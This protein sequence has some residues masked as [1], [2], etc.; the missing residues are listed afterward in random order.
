MKNGILT[1]LSILIL[2]IIIPFETVLSNN[3]NPLIFGFSF[4]IVNHKLFKH[5]FLTGLILTITFSYLAFFIGFFGLFGIGEIIKW[6]TD[7]FNLKSL[8]GDILI[9]FSGLI[10]SLILYLLFTKVY[11]KQNIK[12]GFLIMLASYFLIPFIVLI[13][14]FIFR[15]SRPNEFFVI[16]NLSWL[17]IVGF[18]LSFTLNFNRKTENE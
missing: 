10:A 8:N 7:I 18:F 4:G 6:I 17:L 1:A 12:K 14:P 3:L 16:Y 2:L 5:N 9:L 15:N 11:K 13:T